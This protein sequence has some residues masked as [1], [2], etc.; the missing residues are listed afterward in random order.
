MILRLEI[1]TK[2]MKKNPT[3]FGLRR[4]RGVQRGLTT[5]TLVET[6]RIN[7]WLANQ[8]DETGYQKSDVPFETTSETGEGT[9]GED[10]GR[11]RSGD[12]LMGHILGIKTRLALK[13]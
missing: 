11:I 3:T 6:K 2:S 1:W 9:M 12:H 8:E 13:K 7:K 10:N 4:R 5:G